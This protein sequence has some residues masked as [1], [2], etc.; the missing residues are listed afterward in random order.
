ML[1]PKGRLVL[2]KLKG[3]FLGVVLVVA[4]CG[5]S[6]SGEVVEDAG[7]DDSG[8]TSTTVDGLICSDTS[9]DIPGCW[10]T[11]CDPA[12]AEF[13][14]L[15]FRSVVSFAN[16]GEVRHYLQRFDNA[17]C[18]EPAIRT[19]Q[20]FSDISFELFPR[21]VG[22]DEANVEG[23]IQFELPEDNASNELE[24][25]SLTPYDITPQGELCYDTDVVRFFSTGWSA[26]YSQDTTAMIS[27]SDCLV[28][29]D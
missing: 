16:S 14:D 15:Y 26:T 8:R 24:R 29:L 5:G 9:P 21:V 18:T 11:S 25:K 13:E 19:D 4:G 27:Y 1:F 20:L 2:V 23:R 28:A 6:G 3:M 22:E 7:T 12:R 10:A 17:N